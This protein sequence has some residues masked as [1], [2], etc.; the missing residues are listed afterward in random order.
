[1]CCPV[2]SAP[3]RAMTPPPWVHVECSGRVAQARLPFLATSVGKRSQPL[4]CPYNYIS[5]RV[6]SYSTIAMRHAPCAMR[7]HRSS[8]LGSVFKHFSSVLVLAIN[9][10]SRAGRLRRRGHPMS[11]GGAC[12]K[13]QAP[14][15]KPTHHILLLLSTHQ[16]CTQGQGILDLL[17][18]SA[19]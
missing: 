10:D 17:G 7:Q 14:S 3:K 19:G 13:P 12:P 5:C 6:V 15:P 8:A 1:M 9:Q 16:F 4:Q 11:L 2:E 18:Q